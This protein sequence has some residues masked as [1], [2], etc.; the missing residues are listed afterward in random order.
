[1]NKKTWPRLIQGLLVLIVPVLLVTANLRIVTGH[2]FVRWEYGKTGFPPDPFGLSTAERTSLAETC[3]D[4][5]A[6]NA[7]ISLLAD[8]RLPGG[9]PAF[10]TRELQHM[11]DVQAVFHALTLTGIVAALLFLGSTLLLL[12]GHTRRRVPA[13]L[14]SGGLLTLGLLVG[15]GATMVLSWNEFFTAFHRI[16]FEGESWIF[17]YSDTLIRLFP[18]RLWMDVGAVIVGLLAIEAGALSVVGWA[19]IRRTRR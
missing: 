5:L 4:Y 14:L 13:A 16:F 19:W 3:V 15:V 17:P 11:A 6:T 8:L 9:D 10:N 7:D 12:R 18:T 2:W 1:M